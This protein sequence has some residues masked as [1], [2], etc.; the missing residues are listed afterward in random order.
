MSE[1]THLYE[2]ALRLLARRPHSRLELQRKLRGVAGEVEAVLDRLCDNGYIDD[3]KFAAGL[4]QERRRKHW[5]DRAILKD[6]KRRGVSDAIV[7]QTMADLEC[8]TGEGEALQAW[9]ALCVGRRGVPETPT[10]LKKLYDSCVRRGFPGGETRA[11]LETYFRN[12]NW[13]K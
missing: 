3:C 11:A 12:L 1:S 4:A 13:R 10:Q 5:S 7:Q 9:I 8:E 2:R 6:L